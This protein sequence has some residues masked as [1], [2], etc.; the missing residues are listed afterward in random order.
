M[1]TDEDVDTSRTVVQVYVP[2]Y[3]RDAWDEHAA[4]LDMSRSEFVGTMVQAGRRGFGAEPAGGT[5]EAPAEDTL[6]GGDSQ[7]RERILE[8]LEAEGCL[9]WEE[10]LAEVTGN[11]ETRLEETLQELQDEDTVRYNG[12]EGGYLLDEPGDS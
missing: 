11:I 3:Q 2:A 12:R 6:P 1:A 7:L 5:G 4:K 8:S 9:S 10:L